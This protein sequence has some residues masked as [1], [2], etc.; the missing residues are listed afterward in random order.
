MGPLVSYFQFRSLDSK[1]CTVL[2]VRKKKHFSFFEK[3]KETTTHSLA[4]TYAYA[5]SYCPGRPG[6][7]S[8]RQLFHPL[9][10]ID[11][12]LNFFLFLFV[13]CNRIS[14]QPFLK[15]SMFT[16]LFKKKHTS[17]LAVDGSGSNMTSVRWSLQTTPAWLIDRQLCRPQ[18][19]WEQYWMSYSLPPHLT[20]SSQN[21]P[22]PRPNGTSLMIQ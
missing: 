7:D 14:T 16:V 21:L 11:F 17:P 12:A 9:F 8:E 6:S 1:K 19:L 13:S 18:S 22:F 2:F 10:S 20:S 15:K 4:S 3:A 5:Q